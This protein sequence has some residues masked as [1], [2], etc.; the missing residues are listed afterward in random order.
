[1]A[2]FLMLGI[3]ALFDARRW[4]RIAG[5]AALFAGIAVRYN[6]FAAT[7]PIVVLLFEV[8]LGVAGLRRYAIAAAAWLAVTLAAFGLNAAITDQKMYV[9]HA[10]LAVYDIAGTLS[11]VDGELSDDQL[12]R[13]LAGT[14]L[15][16]DHA[17]H[18]AIRKV[19]TPRDFYPI[20]ADPK[21]ALWSLPINGYTPAPEPQRDA[22]ARA[23]WDVIT[24]HPRAYLKHRLAVMAQVLEARSAEVIVRREFQWP[25]YAK[26]VGLGTGWSKLQR[27]LTRLESWIARTT[28]VFTP[29]LYA[30]LALVMLPLARGQRDVFALLLGGLVFEST[31]VLLAP[32][33]DYRYSHWLVICTCI[34]VIVLTARRYRTAAA[35]RLEARK[36]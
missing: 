22:I 21:L 20:L 24:E 36:K 12:R 5:L 14:G 28:P 16:V 9:W 34:S 8:R 11:D 1:M 30:L 13:T 4:V 19:Y 33:S 7:L 31:L 29:W 10:G 25:E 6:G 3:G 27:K 17:I 15:L 23:W 2:G 35:Y 32:S 26:Q 18:A